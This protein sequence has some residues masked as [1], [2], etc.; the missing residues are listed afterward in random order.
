MWDPLTSHVRAGRCTNSRFLIVGEHL[1]LLSDLLHGR[2]DL[3]RLGI[4]LPHRQDELVARVSAANPRTVVVLQTGSPVALP[5]LDAVPAVL[6]AWYPGQEC[7][8]AIA[9]V[10]LGAAEPGGRLPQAWPLRLEDTVAFGNPAAYPGVDGQVQYEEGVF[11]GYR[12]HQQR[13]AAVQFPFGHGLSYTEFAY[14]PLRGVPEQIEPGQSFTVEMAVRNTGQRAGQA[15]VQLYVH[16]EAASV[17]HPVR[18]LKSFAKL[19]LAPGETGVS[20]MQVSMRSLAFFDEARAAW[21]AEAGRFQIQAGTSCEH[22]VA[23]ESVHLSADWVEA[24]R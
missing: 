7:G 10:L 22:M 18:E 13:G 21:V 8:N 9:D 19:T 20:R 23:T 14:G 16:D 2:A 24:V 11:I 6:Q 15:V 3:D 17:S 12:H 1:A 4:D 5:W